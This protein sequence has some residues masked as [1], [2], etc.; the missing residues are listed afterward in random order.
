MPGNTSYAAYADIA[1][2]ALMTNWYEYGHGSW[3]DL[4]WWNSA[5]ALEAVINYSFQRNMPT[6]NNVIWDVY[7]NKKSAGYGNF[8]NDYYDDEAWWALAWLRAYDRTQSQEFLNTSKQIFQDMLGGWDEEV[9]TGGIWWNKAR[10]QK[11]AIENELFITLATKLYLRTNN[12]LYLN[13]ALRDWEWFQQT[14]MLGSSGLINDGVNLSTCKSNGLPTWTYNQGVILGGLTDLYNITGDSR[15][16]D[17]ARLIATSAMKSLVNNDGVLTEPCEVSGGDCGADGSQ[18]KGIFVRY[19]SYLYNSEL[20]LSRTQPQNFGSEDRTFV[21]S[22]ESFFAK[23][24]QSIWE[25]NRN[26]QNNF[27]LHWSG[28]FAFFNASTHSSA[29]DALNAAA[30]LS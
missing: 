21:S 30:P 6:I 26:E 18:F 4:G 12:Q 28:P 25:N 19:L 9:C 23:Q 13:W 15:Y 10:K 1:L 22:C 16:R 29:L 24:A 5:N 20:E 27:G 11:N 2:D 3:R 7:N 14:G 8:I 17:T